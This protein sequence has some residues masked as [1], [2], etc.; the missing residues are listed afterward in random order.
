M[1]ITSPPTHP[2]T[3]KYF[4]PAASPFMNKEYERVTYLSTGRRAATNDVCTEIFSV[5]LCVFVSLW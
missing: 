1:Y 4:R 5:N 3:K 2:C